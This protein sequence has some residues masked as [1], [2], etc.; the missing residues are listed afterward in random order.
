MNT[1][2]YVV[3]V[4]IGVTVPP[5]IAYWFI[6]H[7]FAGFWRKLGA[8][9]SFTILMVLLVLGIYGC[10]TQRARIVGQDLGTSVPLLVVGIGLYVVAAWLD[11][12]TRRKLRLSILFGLPEL[13]NTGDASALL[14]DGIYARIRHPRY[15]SFLIGCT[16]MAL[17]AQYLGTYVLVA[18]CFPALLLLARVEEREL[19]ARFGSVYEAYRARVPAFL[20]SRQPPMRG[21]SSSSLDT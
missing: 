15:L 1:F 12:R 19:V 4:L 16:G 20:P 17:M 3:A 8:R 7:P 6:V 21:S 13:R 14:S 18:L 11:R 10:W 5:A 2:R 9:T